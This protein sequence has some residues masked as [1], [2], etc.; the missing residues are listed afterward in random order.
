MAGRGAAGWAKLR[1]KDVWKKYDSTSWLE[2]MFEKADI[3]TLLIDI[4]QNH[5]VEADVE[6][7]WELTVCL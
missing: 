2:T 3:N 4:D 6:T 5:H 1:N 7:E